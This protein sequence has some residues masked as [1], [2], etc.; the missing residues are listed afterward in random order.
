MWTPNRDNNSNKDD[1]AKIGEKKIIQKKEKKNN[2]RLICT[3]LV[4][5]TMCQLYSKIPQKNI[6]KCDL[7]SGYGKYREM[8]AYQITTPERTK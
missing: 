6:V 7:N 2:H 5:T 4:W 1:T 3:I 8:R